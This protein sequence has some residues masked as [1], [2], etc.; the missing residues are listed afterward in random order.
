MTDAPDSELLEQF[1]RDDSEAAFA[2][3]VQR[4]IALV[5]SVALRHTVS[6]QHAQ[7]ITQAVFIVLA[8]KAGSLGR[9]TVLPGWL[10]HTARLTA[11]NWQRAET[12]RVHREQ[13]AFMQST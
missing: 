8:R 6:Q 1:S 9:K 3:L 12:R 2:E 4:H 5:H 13:E 11:A 7:D 10:Y